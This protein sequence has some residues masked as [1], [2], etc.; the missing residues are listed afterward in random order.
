[1]TMHMNTITYHT[2]I[3]NNRQ[4]YTKYKYKRTNNVQLKYF[5]RLLRDTLLT[6]QAASQPCKPSQNLAEPDLARSA[7]AP[8]WGLMRLYHFEAKQDYL[9]SH[10]VKVFPMGKSQALCWNWGNKF[11]LNMRQT[12][13]KSRTYVF[14]TNMERNERNME[15]IWNK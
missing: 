12:W 13:T 8:I 15:Q 10:L 4:K 1:M 9:W 5:E 2:F 11:G 3:T 6:C 14:V 7:P